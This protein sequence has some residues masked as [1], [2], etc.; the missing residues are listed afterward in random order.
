MSSSSA[1]SGSGG[2]SHW[3]F[4]STTF[5]CRLSDAS[6]TFL[7]VF[8]LDLDLDGDDFEAEESLD[9]DLE[10]LDLEEWGDDS[11]AMVFTSLEI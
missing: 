1:S 10:L 6:N 4:S 2:G 11:L 3:N 9:L 8:P 7:T 5:F